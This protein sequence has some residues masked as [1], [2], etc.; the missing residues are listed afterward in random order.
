MKARQRTLDVEK[1]LYI[2]QSS[3]QHKQQTHCYLI[4]I[5]ISCTITLLGVLCF[6]LRI[7]ILVYTLSVLVVFPKTLLHHPT[8]LSEKIPSTPNPKQE[9]RELRDEDFTKK[10]HLSY[11]SDATRR[12]TAFRGWHLLLQGTRTYQRTVTR[13]AVLRRCNSGEQHYIFPGQS[14]VIHHEV[15]PNTPVLNAA[16]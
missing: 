8:R 7:H 1:L 6:S 9:P 16:V 14:A 13:P 12:R 15:K 3:F 10:R 5:S 11:V 4:I 2:R